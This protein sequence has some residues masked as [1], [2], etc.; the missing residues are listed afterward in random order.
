MTDEPET[1][2]EGEEP[3]VRPLPAPL[4]GQAL[5]EGDDPR[6]LPAPREPQM[7]IRKIRKA[8]YGEPEAE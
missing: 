7:I 1:S 5:Q 4:P 2:T 6:P 8:Q 3:D